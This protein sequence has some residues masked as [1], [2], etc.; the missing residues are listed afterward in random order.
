[1]PSADFGAPAVDPV[2][3]TAPGA[4]SS[5]SGQSADFAPGNI[6]S[7]E[8]DLGNSGFSISASSDQAAHPAA[9]AAPRPAKISGPFAPA[10]AR[11]TSVGKGKIV[12]FVLLVVLVAVIL[13][14]VW[15]FKGIGF[16]R[17]ENEP[18][19]AP[20]S[21]VIEEAL[22]SR[23]ELIGG[24][25]QST[26]DEL[27]QQGLSLLQND[28]AVAYREARDSFIQ[29]L[30]VA[31]RRTDAMALY[32]EAT[33]HVRPGT[34]YM[35]SCR[36]LLDLAL[37]ESPD[38]SLVH[39]VNAFLLMREEKEDAALA[40]A[41]KAVRLALPEEQA[42]ALLMQGYVYLH[43]SA[44]V[45]LEKIGQ[46]LQR[47]RHLK[48]A[49]YY[50]GLA[51]ENS[52]DLIRAVK[53]YDE[54]LAADRRERDSLQA[55]VR[56]YLKLGRLEDA[57]TALKTYLKAY[58]DDVSP[59]LWDAALSLRLEKSNEKAA[60]S[61]RQLE[62]TLDRMTTAEKGLFHRLNAE[63]LLGIRDF[64]GAQA[65]AAAAIELDERDGAAHYLAM[66]I[67]IAQRRT[68]E[69]KKHLEGCRRHLQPGLYQEFLGRLALM[70]GSVDDALAAFHKANE[71]NPLRL[72]AL[73]AEGILQMKQGNERA[74]WAL[75]SRILM[76]DPY[77]R[78]SEP[79][80]FDEFYE[81]EKPLLDEARRHL[82]KPASQ[83]PASQWLYLI[84]GALAGFHSGDFKGS[85]RALD[86]VI[87]SEPTSLIS[88][89]YRAQ[90]ELD[91]KNDK[92][93]KRF[94]DTALGFA[95]RESSAWYMKAKYCAAQKDDR[96]ARDAW[97]KVL[98]L[99]PRHVDAEIQLARLSAAAGDK[100]DAMSRLRR[101]LAANPHME[102]V[103]A[104]LFELER[105]RPAR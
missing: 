97:I 49:I 94:V 96:C 7:L 35:D 99:A 11:N 38:A 40:E 79:P 55:L 65:A 104:Q 87:S 12:L 90:M 3:G 36:A 100:A 23:P 102:H 74:A 19:P 39:R 51:A 80:S 4:S 76:L 50:Q 44:P 72:T 91:Q 67:G 63:R 66:K 60:A 34:P 78:I 15:N 30:S 2:A 85:A 47:N 8:L 103:R 21:A 14:A 37:A 82:T 33:L 101:V 69:A 16:Q 41:D 61:L 89:V 77:A 31:P 6:P 22:R 95:S 45:A 13:A 81:P 32:V 29:A 73:L 25:K 86:Q 5:S 43:K 9:P 1:M 64:A 84:Y 27:I 52:G 20:V 42:D 88:F 17:V 28:T 24:A 93:A 10:V 83:S 98:E 70:D 58:P 105:V 26:A 92:K 48:R 46:A 68:A 56:V 54:R 71:E 18:P 59:K 57:R 53:S 75:H 62:K